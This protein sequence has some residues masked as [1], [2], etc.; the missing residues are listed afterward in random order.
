MSDIFA[1]KPVS[2]SDNY[3][4]YNVIEKF[5]FSAIYDNCP[6][7]ILDAYSLYNINTFKY[8]VNIVFINSC[9]KRITELVIKLLCYSNQ[10]IPFKKIFYTYSAVKGNIGKKDAMEKYHFPNNLPFF[11]KKIDNIV[12][13]G[14]EFGHCV[15]IPIPETYFKKMKL[16][17]VSVKY[18]DGSFEDLSLCKQVKY[19]KYDDLNDD[20]RFAYHLMNIYNIAEEE[21]PIRVIPMQSENSWL[22][23]CGRKNI[24]SDNIC[25]K[26]M[27]DKD[28]QLKNITKESFDETIKN[29]SVES[30][31]E[32]VHH[33]KSLRT[34]VSLG[35]ETQEEVD[36]KIKEYEKVL[37]NVAKKEREN[38]RRIHGIFLRII[39][40]GIVIAIIVF[41]LRLIQIYKQ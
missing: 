8:Y 9:K 27:R 10:N 23:C 13:E 18:D 30:T 21:H 15:Y 24:N 22:C 35:L 36:R 31:P 34:P 12:S 6:V 40:A 33:K 11:K 14:E 20:S 7:D 25:K 29:E 28:W 26:C 37:E 32:F 16:E 17:F 4:D 5:D 19:V 2:I 3:R 1:S 38:E 41:I 39:I